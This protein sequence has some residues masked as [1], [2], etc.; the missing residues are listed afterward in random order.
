MSTK[1]MNYKNYVL[2]LRKSK[3]LS[4]VEMAK[5]L[6]VSETTIKSI[7][8]NRANKPNSKLL[9]SIAK[10]TKKSIVEVVRDIY[11]DSEV[12]NASNSNASIDLL[13][14]YS[15]YCILQKRNLIQYSL[16]K[17]NKNIEIQMNYQKYP[18]KLSI[19]YSLN[20]FKLKKAYNKDEL[21][22]LIISGPVLQYTYH[23]SKSNIR[24]IEIVFDYNNKKE[25]EL[26][27]SINKHYKI[28]ADNIEISFVLFDKKRCCLL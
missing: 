11:F 21:I 22:D 15:A 19:F 16:S 17:S 18:S 8:N 6:N 9:K 25:K 5:F 13:S 26:Y 23:N 28:T 27:N 7:E 12:I 4:Q 20:H 2:T 14:K 3:N 24:S 10:F 1:L